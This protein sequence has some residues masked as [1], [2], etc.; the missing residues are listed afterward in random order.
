MGFLAQMFQPQAMTEMEQYVQMIQRG[1][2]N[3]SNSGKSITPTT[4][5]QCSAVFACVNVISQTLA[6]LP[7]NLYRRTTKGKEL[8][9]DHPLFYLM[10]MKPN[11]FHNSYNY[12]QFSTAHMCLRGNAYSFKNKVSGGRIYELVPLHPDSV[13]VLQDPWTGDVTYHVSATKGI[14]G[15]FTKDQI[16]HVMGMTL[17]G[18]T[19]VSPITYARESIGLA[20]A[21]EEHGARLFSNGARPTLVV[22]TPGKISTQ[23]FEQ[24]KAAFYEQMV[25]VGNSGKPFFAEEGMD[26]SPLS[27]SMDD[28]QFLETRQHQVPEIARFYRMPLHK[29][30]DLTKSTNN[31][32][33]HQSLEFVSDTM[34][35]WF[36]CWEQS[37]NTQLLTID[38][39]KEYF[40]K[41]D[42]DD[43]LRAD[44]KSRFEAYAS[45]ISSEIFNPN[46]CREKEDMN[47]YPGGEKYMNRNTKPAAL[48]A[49]KGADNAA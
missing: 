14:N 5:M 6:Q 25:G 11:R 49:G 19:G 9:K 7:L 43:I 23:T 1:G 3:P 36:V 8:A 44:M 15:T 39:Q 2:F 24:M 10:A 47:P 31:N 46:E 17:N 37:M 41:F 28:A 35:P 30:Q 32:I 29:I 20:L 27:M 45:G 12:R 40:F 22:K 13:S 42:V 33:E 18:Y 48:T 4:A 34:M 38:E 16:F 21:T 26:V